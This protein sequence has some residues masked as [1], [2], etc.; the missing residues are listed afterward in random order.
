MK[1]SRYTSSALG[2]DPESGLSQGSR[3]GKAFNAESAVVEELTKRLQFM[4]PIK[5]LI[6]DQHRPRLDE[7]AQFPGHKGRGTVK[8]RIQMQHQARVWPQAGRVFRDGFGKPSL[9]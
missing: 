8:V 4:F 5:E 2:G 7:G 3:G 1:G 9:E 6:E